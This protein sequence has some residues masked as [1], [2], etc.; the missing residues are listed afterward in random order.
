MGNKKRS[1]GRKL[2][3]EGKKEDEE[4]KVCTELGGVLRYSVK[5]DG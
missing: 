2:G 1:S 4:K 3:I 5:K